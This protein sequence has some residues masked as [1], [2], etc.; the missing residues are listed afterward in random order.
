LRGGDAHPTITDNGNLVADLDC[1][2]IP[3][4]DALAAAL[5]AIPGVVEHGLFIGICSGLIV[6]RPDGVEVIEAAARGVA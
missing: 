1:E 5:S 6:G 3:D 4:P 2:L